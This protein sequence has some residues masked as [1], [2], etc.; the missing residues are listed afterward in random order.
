MTKKAFTIDTGLLPSET[1][2]DLGASGNKFQQL[3]LSGT[4]NVAGDLEV[5]GT[6][7]GPGGSAPTIVGGGGGGGLS[8]STAIAY[9]IALG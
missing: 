7:T 8:D 9:A 2:A 4:A 3:H 6:I 1:T 5:T